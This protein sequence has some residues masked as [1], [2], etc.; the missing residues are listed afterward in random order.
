MTFLQLCQALRREARI[1]G[2]I[3]TVVD[4]SGIYLDVVNWVINAWLD[5]QREMPNWLFMHEDFSFDTIA[6]QR[7][8][9]AAGVGITDLRD[10]DTGSFLIYEKTIGATDQ[11]ELLFLPYARWRAQYRSQMTVRSTDRPQLFTLL[12]NNSV[13]FEPVPDAIFTVDGEYKR[14]S[15]TFI[16]NA[17]TPT[18]FPEDFHPMIYWRALMTYGHDQ[19]APD[20]LDKAEENYDPLSHRLYLEQLPAMNTDYEALA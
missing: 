17:D 9:T 13:R 8:Y 18:G 7:D 20:A 10:W 2:E 6:S 16:A 19:N 15:Q 1:S 14:S 11:N 4:Q 12:P 3:S 5:I